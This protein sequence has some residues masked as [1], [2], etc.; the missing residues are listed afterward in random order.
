[1][2]LD[3]LVSK[4]KFDEL[5]SDLH[6]DEIKGVFM[7][8]NVIAGVDRPLVTA[9]VSQTRILRLVQDLQAT[10]IPDPYLHNRIDRLCVAAVSETGWSKFDN[11]VGDITFWLDASEERL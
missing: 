1:M 10:I 7:A 9:S 11:P 6:P 8:E 2:L 5:L 4:S 3:A